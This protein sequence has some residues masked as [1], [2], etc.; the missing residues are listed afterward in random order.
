VHV[1][2]E[3][4]TEPTAGTGFVLVKQM[5]LDVSEQEIAFTQ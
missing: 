5:L 2:V 1:K 4:C 3:I